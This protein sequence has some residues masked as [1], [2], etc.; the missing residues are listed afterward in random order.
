MPAFYLVSERTALV[1]DPGENGL[2][3]LATFLDCTGC[4][5]IRQTPL[6][7]NLADHFSVHVG[8]TEMAALKFVGQ[9]RM[10]DAETVENG[11]V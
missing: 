9:P 8:E 10:V 4:C 6:R 11:R 5:T 2:V 3:R 7:Q 1:P